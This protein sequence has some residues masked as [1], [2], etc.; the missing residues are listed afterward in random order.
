MSLRVDA[1]DV[2]LFLGFG[3]VVLGVGMMYTPAAWIVVGILLVGYGVAQGFVS[4]KGAK[5]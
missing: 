1:S 4:T 5:K 3:A 2:A